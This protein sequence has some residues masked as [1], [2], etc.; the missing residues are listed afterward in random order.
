MPK[1]MVNIV[2]G[3]SFLYKILS[4]TSELKI[5]LHLWLWILL[6]IKSNRSLL[7]VSLQL[8]I[9]WLLRTIRKPSSC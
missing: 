6:L 4:T 9:N 8:E 3:I 5:Q 7:A 2:K 1:N